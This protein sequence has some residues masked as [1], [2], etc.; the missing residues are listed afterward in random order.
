VL[1]VST[2][3]GR[4]RRCR[5]TRA[6]HKGAKEPTRRPGLFSIR[7]FSIQRSWSQE[8]SGRSVSSRDAPGSSFP[9]CRYAASEIPGGRGRFPPPPVAIPSVR[10]ASPLIWRM[11]ARSKMRRRSRH[12]SPLAS[13]N[14]RTIADATSRRPLRTSRFLFFY[15]RPRRYREGAFL[16]RIKRSQRSDDAV[17]CHSPRNKY[18]AIARRVA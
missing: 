11:V 5:K 3:P 17:F 18:C 13:R 8:R 14:S 6:T 7:M 10:P 2:E 12:V 15:H 9:S 16:T 4:N 1:I